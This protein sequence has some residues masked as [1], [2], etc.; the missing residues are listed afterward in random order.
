MRP[1]YHFPLKIR[2]TNNTII[3]FPNFVTKTMDEI[4]FLILITK[5]ETEVFLDHKHFSGEYDDR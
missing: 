3:F 1:K 5:V 2:Y 4:Y